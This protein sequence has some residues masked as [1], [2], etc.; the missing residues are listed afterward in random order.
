MA[1][2]AWQFVAG[3]LVLASQAG[4]LGLCPLCRPGRLCP[5]HHRFLLKDKEVQGFTKKDPNPAP[6]FQVEVLPASPTNVPRHP[7]EAGSFLRPSLN[8]PRDTTPTPKSSA[9]VLG[10]PNDQKPTS[11]LQPALPGASL[12]PMPGLPPVTGRNLVPAKKEP[13]VEA[14]GCVLDNRPNEALDHLQIYDRATQELF[15]RLLPLLA[16][17]THKSFDQLSPAEVAVLYDQLQ[18]LLVTLRPRTELVIGKMC[19]CE[20]VKS[21]G[22]YQSLP[23]DH[24]FQAGT[25]CQPG[26]LVQLYVELPNVTSEWR[27]PYH[28]TR[29]ASSVEIADAKGQKVGIPGLHDRKQ[30]LRSLTRMNDYF[31]IYSFHM[32]HLAP[33]VYTLTLQ[34]TDETRPDQR[35]VARKALNLTVTNPCLRGP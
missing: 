23:K 6:E 12:E 29:L 33:G 34:V 26:E 13:L 20:W 32:P 8:I 10:S 19:F 14:L 31:N 15:L 22:L 27:D 16:Q 28:E 3:F 1:R 5:L 30:P 18:S 11:L 4:C 9:P 35:R 17:I 7:K 25:D 24:V 21:Y 2:R